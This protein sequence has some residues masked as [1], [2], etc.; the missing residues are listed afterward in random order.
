ML[1]ML[2]TTGALI[3]ICINFIYLRIKKNEEQKVESKE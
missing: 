2:P 1:Q 3:V